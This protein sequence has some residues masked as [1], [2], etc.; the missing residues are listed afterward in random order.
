MG[1]AIARAL[2]LR[3]PPCRP[4][5]A[6]DRTREGAPSP[7]PV[8]KPRPSPQPQACRRNQSM[9]RQ[10]P[11]LGLK[12]VLHELR[13]LGQYSGQGAAGRRK[14]GVV[15]L[16]RSCRTDV[17]TKYLVRT[18]IQVGAARASASKYT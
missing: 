7:P 16:L 12:A 3:L 1:L 13:Q 8:V 17:E 4:R 18:L 2:P 6:E 11:P 14:G 15:R 10:P 9:L 5:P